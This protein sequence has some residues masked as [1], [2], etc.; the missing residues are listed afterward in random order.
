MLSTE[1]TA[2]Y[3]KGIDKN[4]DQ[5][6]ETLQQKRLWQG[7]SFVDALSAEEIGILGKL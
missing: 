3:Q 6:F 5:R 4:L 1:E 2:R 7:F